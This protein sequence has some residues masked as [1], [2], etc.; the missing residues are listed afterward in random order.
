MAD[1]STIARPYAKALFDLAKAD[2]K[3]GP[4]SEALNAASAVLAEPNAKRVLA[5][6]TLDQAKRADFIRA[7]SVGLK[8]ADLFETVHGKALLALLAEND[9]LAVLP[10]IAA[11]FDALKAQAENK[12]KVTFISA[13]AADP[14]VVEQVTEALKKRLGR[15]V[16]MELEV[17]AGLIG[18]AIIRAEDMVID[19]SVRARLE[20]LAH[21]LIDR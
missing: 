3:L 18:G 21:T 13:T 8:G 7:M 10:E 6:P 14:K 11:Q 2:K 4:W 16:E 1:Q 20:K 5:N 12:V 15:E 9:R 17:D 19:G